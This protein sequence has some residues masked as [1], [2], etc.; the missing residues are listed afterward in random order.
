MADLPPVRVV[1]AFDLPPVDS[2]AIY[3]AVAECYVPGGPDTVI[4]ARPAS[5]YIC[6]GYHQDLDREIDVA[7]CERHGLPVYRRQVGGGA[8]YLD[9]NQVFLQWVFG[10]RHLPITLESRYQLYAKPLIATYVSYGV[11]AVFRPVNDIHVGNR[12]IGGTGAATVGAAEVMV[13]SI[14]FNIDADAMAAALRVDSEKMRDKIAFSIKEYVTSLTRE[15]GR[16]IPQ[17]EVVA[18]YLQH[19]DVALGRTHY[20]G[21][22]TAEE[23]HRLIQVRERFLQPGWTSNGGGR[24]VIGTK[25]HEGVSV[26][27]GVYKAPG[28]LVRWILLVEDGTVVDATLEGDFTI[29]P[30]DAPASLADLIVG[31]QAEPTLLAQLVLA[32]FPAI[33][34]SSPGLTA[35]D[36]IGALSRAFQPT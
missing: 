22:L 32:G 28:G 36:V 9:R 30:G 6:I 17:D 11:P 34:S 21:P 5:P 8:V 26:L 16:E 2:Q 27:Q 23:E 15:T 24:R 13:G 31:R 1:T 18:T 35:Q 7:A 10:P 33:V 12:K 20:P 19:L 25:I 4:L 3:H 14:L 29:A